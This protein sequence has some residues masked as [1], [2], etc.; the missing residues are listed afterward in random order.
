MYYC[1]KAF[2]LEIFLEPFLRNHGMNQ[3]IRQRKFSQQ[4]FLVSENYI[5]KSFNMNT[6][7]LTLN[8][9]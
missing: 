7:S 8:K 6:N 2:F 3:N 1:H 5:S 9:L 4:T